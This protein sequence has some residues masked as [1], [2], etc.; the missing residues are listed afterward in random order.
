MLEAKG[1]FKELNID[2]AARA[3]AVLAVRLPPGVA[4]FWKVTT[5]GPGRAMG[6]T[7]AETISRSCQKI[8]D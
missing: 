1:C 3:D 7:I 8:Q 2:H 6:D 4:V 5:W